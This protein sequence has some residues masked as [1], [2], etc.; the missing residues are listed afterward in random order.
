M[1]SAVDRTRLCWLTK[2]EAV[3]LTD[4]FPSNIM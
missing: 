2:Q 1:I 4:N 3:Q